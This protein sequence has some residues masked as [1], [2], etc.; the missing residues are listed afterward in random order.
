MS[1]YKRYSRRIRPGYP[2]ALPLAITLSYAIC[3]FLTA[4]V[5]ARVVFA[6][7]IE[8]DAFISFRVV[9]NFLQGYGL[10]WNIHERVQVYTNPL[11]TL[12]H[13][14][15][16]A[17]TDNI[18]IST[19]GLSWACLLGALWLSYR[20]RPADP[21]RFAALFLAPFMLSPTLVLFSTSGLETPLLNLLFCGIGYVLIRKPQRYWFWL[22]L[23]T[24]LSLWT[25]LDTVI[26]YAPL[27][28]YL[29]TVHRRDIK[30]RQVFAG[31]LPLILWFSFSLF[32]YG[33][34]LPN[35]AL[36]K[37]GASLAIEDYLHSGIAYLA[38]FILADPVGAL[39]VGS[40]VFLVREGVKSPAAALAMGVLFYSVY[41][42][43]VG[44]YQLS[45][46]MYPL[47]V[48]AALW[49]FWWKFRRTSWRSYASVTF[50]VLVAGGF[51]AMSPEAR[52]TVPLIAKADIRG[53]PM[54]VYLFHEYSVD[55]N[56]LNAT[57]D[58]TVR[59][60]SVTVSG[61][62]GMYGYYHGPHVAIIDKYG[63]SDPLLARL[64]SKA[65]RM[66]RIG[67]IERDIPEG[68]LQAV[69]SDAIGAMHPSL[70]EYYGK[71]RIIAQG[72]LLDVERLE[73]ILHFNL[74]SY[75]VLKAQYIV[76]TTAKTP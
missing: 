72:E 14:P 8:E 20:A 11:W 32:Y 52:Y 18:A 10:R 59:P 17:I 51:F 56:T 53:I 19:F 40:S 29:M 6:S 68:Y 27:W 30:W 23:L 61:T 5:F 49:L 43:Y 22:S 76:E 28:L 37:L 35:T 1:L 4:A 36:A 44:G 24:A 57:P 47:P 15:V 13:I 12:L 41:V 42:V 38:D 33:F 39:L 67:H 48:M 73:T 46:R 60:R 3:F 64:P 69:E 21:L 54:A 66:E 16:Q 9:D 25:R 26:F 75:D 65:S 50:T 71:L 55:Q 74:G 58:R 7:W 31:G 62:I 34:V 70:A 45:L 63:L 2:T